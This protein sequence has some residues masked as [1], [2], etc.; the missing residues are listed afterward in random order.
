MFAS[1]G[2][3]AFCKANAWYARGHFEQREKSAFA[4]FA[5]QLQKQIFQKEDIIM[6][7]TKIKKDIF[8]WLEEIGV[9]QHL[10][11]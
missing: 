11:S 6:F 3:G 5:L 1:G 8:Y 2:S 4:A 10:G 7:L 9:L